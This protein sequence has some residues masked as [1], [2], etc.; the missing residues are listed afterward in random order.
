MEETL[1]VMI[2]SGLSA[3]LPAGGLSAGEAKSAEAVAEHMLKVGMV[4][5]EEQ[6][7]EMAI[8]VREQFDLAGVALAMGSAGLS[9]E[10]GAK[11]KVD[12]P[13][14]QRSLTD[15]GTAAM[16]GVVRGQ[17]D[18]ESLATQLIA[19]NVG[20][21]VQQMKTPSKL[22]EAYHQS[23]QAS[24]GR[25]ANDID[26]QWQ[27]EFINDAKLAANTPLPS[28]TFDVE[29]PWTAAQLG[30]QV[31]EAV[32]RFE[33]VD[34][35]RNPNGFWQRVERSYEN[36]FEHRA[37]IAEGRA[38]ANSESMRES[39]AGATSNEQNYLDLGYSE[40]VVETRVAEWMA[41]VVLSA[42][43]PVIRAAAAAAK[44]YS[45][46]NKWGFFGRQSAPE[47]TLR[48]RVLG[49]ITES[50]A[51]RETSNFL[52]L[53]AKEDQILAG[54]TPDAWSMINLCRGDVVYGGIPGQS[55]YYTSERTFLA[56]GFNRD[57]LFQS[58]QVRADPILGYRPSVGMYEV[59]KNIRVP[60]GIVNA[61]PGLGSGTGEQFYVN[62]FSN[63]LKLVD[64]IKLEETYNNGMPTNRPR[65]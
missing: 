21:M 29:D 1:T 65:S 3:Q 19:D 41:P 38:A 10:L 42:A 58:L 40:S 14:V 31:G 57:A 7:A 28:I 18:M 53:S 32:S 27:T 59:T 22:E 47:D 12:N 62:N 43:P 55:V 15:I 56:S 17:F 33:H 44:A 51:A 61:N 45:L 30:Q 37:L 11:L 4:N 50:Q 48:Q 63:V 46:A 36:V 60:Y 5:V 16:S 8:G 2:T 34:L 49:N 24:Q 6:F 64:R 52:V 20:V 9:A 26:E 13:W 35:P 25:N 39:L 23:Q 54:Y